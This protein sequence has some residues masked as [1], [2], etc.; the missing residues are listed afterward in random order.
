MGTRVDASFGF[1]SWDEE[2]VGTADGTSI[3]RVVFVKRFEGG[4]TGRST[5]WMTMAQH[6]SGSGAYGGSERYE[7]TVDGRSGTF[8]A[9]HHAGGSVASGFGSSV[10]VLEGSATGDLDGLTG[11]LEITRH[12][13]GSHTVTLD[14]DLP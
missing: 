11:S 5:G 2:D 7:V 13:D 4:I 1:D 14:Y 10:E 3:H 8:V 9:Q 12:D 6:E